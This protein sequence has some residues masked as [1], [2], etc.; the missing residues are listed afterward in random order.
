MPHKKVYAR[1]W[2]KEDLMLMAGCVEF[3]GILRA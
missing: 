1:L 3:G 2:R